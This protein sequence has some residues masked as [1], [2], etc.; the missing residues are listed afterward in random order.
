MAVLSFLPKLQR[1]MGLTFDVSFLHDPQKC[2]LFHILS[3]ETVSMSYLFP[4]SRYQTKCGIK[5]LF[6]QLM[7]S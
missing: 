3:T 5:F 6:R 1:G 4:F 7:T 2:F